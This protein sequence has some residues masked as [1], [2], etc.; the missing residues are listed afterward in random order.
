MRRKYYWVLAV[1]FVLASAWAVEARQSNKLPFKGQ[2]AGEPDG[3]V[4]LVFSLYDAKG[5]MKL[6]EEMQTVQVS[7]EL[8]TVFIEIPPEMRG[9]NSAI[10]VE[11]AR[12]S[13]PDKS[14]G[15][16]KIQLKPDAKIQG[17][18]GNCVL[19]FTCGGDWPLFGGTHAFGADVRELG[20]ECSGG[21]MTR[22]DN[23][24]LCC[25]S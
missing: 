2:L 5:G 14:I 15:N 4:P 8:F 3:D 10:W 6:F 19:C 7:E 16:G 25:A 24:Q 23:P 12:A 22:D 21:F 1:L 17:G 11:F 18:P 20:L 13:A 9:S